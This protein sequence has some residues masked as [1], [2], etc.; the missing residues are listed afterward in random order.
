M[1]VCGRS[2]TPTMACRLRD[3]SRIDTTLPAAC[4]CVC[5]VWCVVCVCGLGGLT[6][7]FRCS[8]PCFRHCSTRKPSTHTRPTS[9]NNCHTFLPVT[10]RSGR[11]SNSSSSLATAPAREPAAHQGDCATARACAG[12]AEGRH[13]CTYWAFHEGQH[14]L[15]GRFFLRVQLQSKRLRAAGLW[16]TEA[17]NVCATVAHAPPGRC[18]PMRA[19]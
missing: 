7:C 2:S 17:R 1:A 18:C 3:G 4:V 5:G 15:Q 16:R 11:A 13:A 14:T 10:R 19:G 6:M 9:A 8:P 12:G